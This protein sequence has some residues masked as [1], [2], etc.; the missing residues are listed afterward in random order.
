MRETLTILVDAHERSNRKMGGIGSIMQTRNY[1]ENVLRRIAQNPSLFASQS[2]WGQKLTLATLRSSRSVSSRSAS[3][4]SVRVSSA[5]RKLC[6]IA[7][8]SFCAIER[9][10]PQTGKIQLTIVS[11]QGKK[12]VLAMMGPR[13]FL[14]EECLGD[15]RRTSTAT[16]LG[17]LTVF[18]IEKRYASGH[19]PHRVLRRFRGF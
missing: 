17:P 16:S 13:D 19:S 5:G 10:V 9:S 14:G 6:G 15:S 3:M 8:H 12:A 18:R 4:L 11:S 2:Q 7:N 1:P